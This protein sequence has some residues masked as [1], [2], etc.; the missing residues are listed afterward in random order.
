MAKKSSSPALLIGLALG[1][2]GLL[3]GFIIERG[4]PLNLISISALI[5]ILGGTLGALTISVGLKSVLSI[6]KLM[7][8]TLKAPAP[9]GPETLFVR[10]GRT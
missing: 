3:V 5:I 10:R 1:L 2:G 4:N 9:P 6:P 7:I 8:G